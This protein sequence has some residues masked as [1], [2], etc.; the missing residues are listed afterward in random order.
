MEDLVH[1]KNFTCTR[2][3]YQIFWSLVRI[4]P[5]TWTLRPRRNT[6]QTKLPR[7]FLFS[8]VINHHRETTDG[9]INTGLG[10]IEALVSWE[11]ISV[12]KIRFIILISKPRPSTDPSLKRGGSHQFWNYRVAFIKISEKSIYSLIDGVIFHLYV[13]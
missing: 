8:Y 5:R 9:E 11:S 2:R 6:Q 1:A 3:F 4:K 10:L 12:I 7:P 13:S